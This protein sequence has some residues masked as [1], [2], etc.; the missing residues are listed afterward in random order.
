M[1]P[2][3]GQRHKAYINVEVGSKDPGELIL[4]AY[5][6]AIQGCERRDM[7]RA[8][9][10]VYE[11]MNGLDFSQGEVAGNLVVMYDWIYRQIKEGKFEE[12]KHFLLELRDAWE[13]VVE[14]EQT[15][16]RVTSTSGGLDTNG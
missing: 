12:A 10:A 2:E 13:Q 8:G 16:Q 3:L 11:L 9:E 4:L 1:T 14:A 6:V 15:R 5:T 7:R